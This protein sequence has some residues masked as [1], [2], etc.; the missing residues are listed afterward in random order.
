MTEATTDPSGSRIFIA[1]VH[2]PVYNRNLQVISTSITNLDLHDIAR[3]ATTYGIE[4]YYVVHP[5]EVQQ[6]LTREIIGYW[7]EGFG[8][9]YNADRRQAFECLKLVSSLEEA[10]GAIT[11]DYGHK[12]LTIATDARI[13]ANSI[14]YR[15]LHQQIQETNSNYLLVFGT[16]WCLEGSLVE[17]A[18]YVLEPVYGSGDYNHLSVRSAVAIIVDRLLGDNWWDDHCNCSKIMV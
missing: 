18:D 14:S 17:N 13:Y 5:L 3:V 10:V 15:A 8:A 16:G 11:E 7:Q 4:R 9:Q 1:L 12:P 6:Q 2:Y